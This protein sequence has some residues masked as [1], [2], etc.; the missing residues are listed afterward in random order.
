M[1]AFV[2]EAIATREQLERDSITCRHKNNNLLVVIMPA[3]SRARQSAPI[4]FLKLAR[5]S[6]HTISNIISNN[7]VRSAEIAISTS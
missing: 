5:I 3:P 6:D 4:T 1:D 7:H 2:I